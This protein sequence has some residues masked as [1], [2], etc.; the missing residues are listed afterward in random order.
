[1]NI[2]RTANYISPRGKLRAHD[3][4]LSMDAALLVLE[5]SRAK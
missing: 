2:K 4:Q 1:M 3:K 5:R